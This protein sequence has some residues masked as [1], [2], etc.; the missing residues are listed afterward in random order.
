MYLLQMKFS[1][2]TMLNEKSGSDIFT[3]L[4]E[5]NVKQNYPTKVKK[6]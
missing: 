3:M 2:E 5:K 4:K 6:K 1:P